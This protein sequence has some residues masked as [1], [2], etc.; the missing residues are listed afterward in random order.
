V[1]TVWSPALPHHLLLRHFV[2][3][4]VLEEIALVALVVAD[5]EG[6]AGHVVLLLAVKVFHDGQRVIV[7]AL[8][9]GLIVRLLHATPEAVLVLDM[10]GRVGVRGLH[11]PV[12]VRLHHYFLARA[13]LAR[14]GLLWLA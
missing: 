4:K 11:H 5:V 10:S 6:I 8:L 14:H 13:R 1:V 3:I 7:W 12:R 9:Q 2:R